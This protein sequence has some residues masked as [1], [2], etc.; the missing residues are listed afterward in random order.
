VRP[1]YSHV[2]SPNTYEAA[3]DESDR[4]ETEIRRSERRWVAQLLLIGATVVAIY[5]AN[6]SISGR[7]LPGCGPEGRCHETLSSEWGYWLN[8]PVSL[9]AS[10]TYLVLLALTFALRRKQQP[11]ARGR[12]WL[13]V[14]ALSSFILA[15]A[16]WFVGLQLFVIE[17]WCKL[18]VVTHLM[19]AG[20]AGILIHSVPTTT[21]ERRSR[22]PLLSTKEFRRRA[23][24]SAALGWSA[25]IAGQLA[26]GAPAPR[27]SSIAP[28]SSEPHRDTS[29]SARSSTP[30]LLT[31][32]GGQFA[33]NTEK[34]PLS[35]P[36]DAG[37]IVIRVPTGDG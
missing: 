30:R 31:L 7:A 37:T 12:L 3:P 13:G 2:G 23:V 8:I 9:P 20:A 11:V 22:E 35:G 24:W 28:T 1:D 32:H 26:V 36:I 17:R 15:A 4:Q 14:L 18:C 19:G 10:A 27:E 33:L 16:V 6:V 25:L 21:R 34:L 5:L 29:S